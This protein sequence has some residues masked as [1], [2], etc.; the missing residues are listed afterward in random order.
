MNA[1]PFSVDLEAPLP[2]PASS[3]AAILRNNPL[4]VDNKVL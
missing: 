1:N 3:E 2:Y 4:L